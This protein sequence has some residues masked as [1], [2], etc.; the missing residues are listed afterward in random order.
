MPTPKAP[1]TPCFEYAP[2]ETGSLLSPECAPDEQYRCGNYDRL[3]M[4]DSGP[5]S[6]ALEASWLGWVNAN[7]GGSPERAEGAAQAARDAVVSGDELN[8]T[9]AAAVNRWIDFG[10]RQKPFWQM[11]VWGIWLVRRAWIYVLFAACAQ[12]FWFLP[13]GWIP[14]VAL[15]PL[16]LGAAVWHL[17]VAYR[18]ANHGIVAPGVL[19]DV[20]AKDS[21]GPV[22]SGTYLWQFHGPHLITRMGSTPRDVLI[23]FD[24]GYP[25]DAVVIDRSFSNTRMSNQESH[26]DDPGGNEVEVIGPE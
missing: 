13:M 19:V 20:I 15:T 11:T 18:L 1:E 3:A 12:V 21:D 2:S 26:V 9:V 16:P 10:P 24:P 8:A 7:L 6:R 25:Q 23:L 17:Y 22:Y 5:T 14:V 4:S